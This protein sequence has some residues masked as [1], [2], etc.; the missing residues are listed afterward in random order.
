MELNEIESDL[1]EAYEHCR[2]N[3][4]ALMQ[5]NLCGCFYCLSIYHPSKIFAWDRDKVSAACPYCLMNSVISESSGYPITMEFLVR[6]HQAWFE[7]E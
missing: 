5:D 3:R 1:I 7:I 6:M 2:N 4:E